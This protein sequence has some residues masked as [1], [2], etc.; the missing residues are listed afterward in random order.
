[1][2]VGDNII[3]MNTDYARD[4]VITLQPAINLHNRRDSYNSDE[5]SEAKRMEFNYQS[6]EID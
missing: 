2:H 5:Q 4:N 3:S 1:M 6:K